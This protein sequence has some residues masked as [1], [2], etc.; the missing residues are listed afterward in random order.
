MSLG[1]NIVNEKTGEVSGFLTNPRI[2]SNFLHAKNGEETDSQN[3][4]SPY[5][6][7]ATMSIPDV[8]FVAELIGCD[9]RSFCFYAV[10]AE[11]FE[12]N[13]F[14]NRNLMAEYL[15]SESNSAKDL[16]SLRDFMRDNP[17][18]KF[19]LDISY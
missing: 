7:P 11:D 6:L 3:S 10:S 8:Y 13:D 12:N 14:F 9:F 1:I 5:G 19:R 2:F 4:G 15:E 16:L 18:E 17:A